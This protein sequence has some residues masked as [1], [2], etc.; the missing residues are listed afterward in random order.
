MSIQMIAL[1]N[2][3]VRYMRQS[4]VKIGTLREVVERIQ[5]GEKVDVEKAL[6]T[7]EPEK[8]TDWEEGKFCV[9]MRFGLVGTNA[10]QY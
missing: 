6:G 10:M 7:G 2:S 4:E 3:F 8:E 9:T 5:R 1:R